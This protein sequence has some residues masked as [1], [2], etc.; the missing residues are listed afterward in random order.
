MM[1]LEYEESLQLPLVLHRNP[2]ISKPLQVFPQCKYSKI[3]LNYKTH[4]KIKI[5][6][7]LFTRFTA[8]FFSHTKILL[9]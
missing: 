9:T 1:T 5:K 3:F 2:D 6:T 7:P 8:S 4:T